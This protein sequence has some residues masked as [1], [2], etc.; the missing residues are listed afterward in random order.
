M[1]AKNYLFLII[2][3]ILCMSNIQVFAYESDLAVKNEDGVIIYYKYIKDG[4]ELE[5]A[6]NSYSGKVNI[7][8]EVTYKNNTLK[9]T[10]IADQAFWGSNVTSVSIPN[11][12]TNI[13][14][15]AFRNCYR[16]TSVTMGNGVSR[17]KGHAFR[18]CEKL[19]SINISNSLSIIEKCV[20]AEC[21]SLKS[22]TIPSS[23]STLD[24]GSFQVCSS[25]STIIIPKSVTSIEGNV[26][27]GCSNLDTITVEKD[28]PFYDSRDN[29]NCIIETETNKLISGCKN[30]TIPNSVTSIGTNAFGG[31]NLD[32]FIIPNNVTTIEATAFSNCDISNVISLIENPFNISDDT[33][34]KVTIYN[35]TLYVPF[36]TIEKYNSR[37]G[38]KLFSSIQEGQP[39]NISNITDYEDKYI[40]I[41]SI[42]G[43]L[44]YKPQ[45]GINILKMKNGKSKKVILK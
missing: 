38:W 31:L 41:Y 9:V 20:F 19:A 12:V 8:E 34:S 45:K 22:I 30:T 2:S 43:R 29:S 16:L 5:V 32:S 10:S 4:S 33:F 1:K 40:K 7:P 24:V 18:A 15:E 26:F 39:S 44:L 17:I 28:N 23:V 13:G 35:A 42:D 3:S 37:D 14:Y 36:G 21:K 25:L 11:S 6:E 27:W